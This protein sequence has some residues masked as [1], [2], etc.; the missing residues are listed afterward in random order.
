MPKTLVNCPKCKQPIQAEIKQLFDTNVD[1]TAKQAI[2]TGAINIIQCPLCGFNGNLASPI[3]YHDAEK[4]LLIT[5]IPPE[6]NLPKNEQER[7]IGNM[8]NQVTNKLPQEKRK[9]YLLQPQATLSMQG[10]VERILEADGITREMLQ[11]QQDRMNLI[12]KLLNLSDDARLETVKQ[13][14]KAID[15]QCFAILDRLIQLTN[16]S[17]D[18]E[19]TQKLTELQSFLFD[20]ST[21]GK[22]LSEQLAEVQA[23]VESL[24]DAGSEL[25]RE[26]LLDI[27]VKAPNQ[28]RLRA[29]V[30]LA[31]PGMDYVFF[32]QLSERIERAR[33]DGRVRLI[34]LRDD[35]L[36]MTSEHDKQIEIRVRN[37]KD[38]LDKILKEDD[39]SLATQKNLSLIDE[40]FIQEVN[41]V[42]ASAKKEENQESIL[43]LEKVINVIQ[44]ASSASQAIAFFEALLEAPDDQTRLEFLEKNQKMLTPEFLNTISSIVYQVQSSEDINAAEQFKAIHR[45]ILKYS[46]QQQLGKT[47]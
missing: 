27:V 25:T 21:F 29:L 7:I 10:M 30:S 47:N 11:E 14:D 8:I 43:K 46:M 19:T 2:L 44:Q 20:H 17:G 3:V 34:Q 32:Q 37:A 6:V 9:A 40:F 24:K 38:L 5:Y 26:K 1:N 31:R 33:T 39:I 41:S 18:Q 15:D 22:Q 4:E 13:E 23:A 12:Q 36:E 28:I 42:L 16:S 35:L 45:L